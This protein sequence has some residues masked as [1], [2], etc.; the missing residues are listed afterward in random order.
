MRR[1]PLDSPIY[2]ACESE[3]E[4]NA[5]ISESS[6]SEDLKSTT[7][8][9]AKPS[10]GPNTATFTSEISIWDD[11]SKRIP[12]LPYCVLDKLARTCLR[13]M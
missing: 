2:I 10:L 1:V 11:E 6:A 13:R 8:E 12:E 7:A 3:L 9:I 5:L 4:V